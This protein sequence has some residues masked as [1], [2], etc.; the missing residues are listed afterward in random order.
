MHCCAMMHV[1]QSKEITP[2]SVFLAVPAQSDAWSVEVKDGKR[3][4]AQ[5]SFKAVD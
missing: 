4:V 3:V 5:I 1:A 2:A